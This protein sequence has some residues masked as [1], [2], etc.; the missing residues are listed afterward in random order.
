MSKDSLAK[1]VMRLDR[2]LVEW[3]VTSSR[4]A[5]R[6]YEAVAL[7]RRHEWIVVDGGEDGDLFYCPECGNDKDFCGHR[8]D[9]ELAVVLAEADAAKEAD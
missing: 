7:L 6:Y 2:Q 8:S 3:R 9:C 1:T 4:W 5:Q